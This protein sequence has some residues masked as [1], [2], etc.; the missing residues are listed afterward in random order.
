MGGG[1]ELNCDGTGDGEEPAQ[2]AGWLGV[3]QPVSEQM[4]GWRTLDPLQVHPMNAAPAS[5]PSGAASSELPA[6]PALA[7]AVDATAGCWEAGL[8][9]SGRASCA[10][11]KHGGY[12]AA[13]SA[14]AVE[15]PGMVASGIETMPPCLPAPLATACLPPT[16]LS[17]GLGP[18]QLLVPCPPAD[19]G[20]AAPPGLPH[21]EAA[22]W[23]APA[24]AT[25][26]PEGAVR[27]QHQEGPRRDGRVGRCRSPATDRVLP[28][29][30]VQQRQQLLEGAAAEAGGATAPGGASSGV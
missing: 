13:A 22:R 29:A 2:R 24:A 3:G 27:G 9:G 1:A 8:S 5:N 4:P 23:E 21:P 19:A 7:G 18:S 12:A 25:A 17:A 16:L 30:A 10:A 14:S 20:E 11:T 15:A 26:L 6:S 28:L